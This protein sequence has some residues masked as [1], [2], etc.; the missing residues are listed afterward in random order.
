MAPEPVNFPLHADGP[1]GLGPLRHGRLV[2]GLQGQGFG[3][4]ASSPMVN[5]LA[6]VRGARVAGACVVFLAALVVPAV[7]PLEA[8]IIIDN[9][10]SAANDRFQDA[11][12]PDQFIVSSLDLS[13]VGQ[14]ANGRWATL[15]GPNTIISANH[16]KPTGS[17]F[18]HPGNDPAAP[19]VE[20][21]I[22]SDVE[23]IA[24][25]DLWLAR[26][27]SHVP[28]QIMAIEYATTAIM[29]RRERKT[30]DCA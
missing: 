14:D 21:G 27:E 12:S 5:L 1:D 3:R 23:R 16:F 17:V 22:S 25:T 10:S 18:F 28:S 30:G 7:L 20:V 29:T 26:L 24:N 2:V 9:Y 11:D 8:A 4:R 15:I 19:G 6:G 13:G